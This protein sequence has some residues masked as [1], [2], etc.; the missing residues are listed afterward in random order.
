MTERGH[1]L[2]P[3]KGS[4]GLDF[5]FCP[6]EKLECGQQLTLWAES[7]MLGSVFLGGDSGLCGPLASH[8]RCSGQT[9]H[10]ASR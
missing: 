6:Q 1:C 7:H 3:R 4:M 10:S 8:S 5:W 2:A 9:L